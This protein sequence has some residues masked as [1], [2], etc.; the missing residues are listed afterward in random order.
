MSRLP[1]WILL[2][3]LALA[4]LP[5]GAN[6][7][8]SWSLLSLVIGILL[9]GWALAAL[10]DPGRVRSAWRHHWIATCL[11]LL[12][13]VWAGVQAVTWTPQ[14]WH[15]PLWGEAGAALGSGLHGAVSL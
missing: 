8:W 13:M 7:P 5:F 10:R 2:I 14:A 6:R 12:L 4:P 9:I 11:F 3:T 15:H 1:Y